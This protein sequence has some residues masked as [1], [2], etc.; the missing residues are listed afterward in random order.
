MESL[1][2]VEFLFPEAS[3]LFYHIPTPAIVNLSP[4]TY[5]VFCLMTKNL[6]PGSPDLNLT[7]SPPGA[8][9]IDV[10]PAPIHI[11]RQVAPIAE[12]ATRWI[13]CFTPI[14]EKHS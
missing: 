5:S 6:K 14:A 9:T 3:L 1:V 10:E 2:F 12:V 11:R 4:L 8:P 7:F 13:K